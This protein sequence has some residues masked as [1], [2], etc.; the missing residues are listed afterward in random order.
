MGILS[1]MLIVFC[2]KLLTGKKIS[3][4]VKSKIQK[5]LSNSADKKKEQAPVT[6]TDK[7]FFKFDQ[8]KVWIAKILGRK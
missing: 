3:W 5:D 8:I 4:P 6:L 1:G 7:L 2:V